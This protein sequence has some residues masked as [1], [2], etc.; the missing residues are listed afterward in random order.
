MLEILDEVNL[1]FLMQS[2]T[3]VEFQN[4][5]SLNYFPFQWSFAHPV[6]PINE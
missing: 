5:V 6:S 2:I 1:Q 3:Q 4:Q